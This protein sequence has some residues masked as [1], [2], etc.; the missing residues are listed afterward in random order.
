MG[1]VL[2]FLVISLVLSLPWLGQSATACSLV[3]GVFLQSNFEMIDAADAIVVAQAVRNDA[4][5]EFGFGT[6]YFDVVEVLKG[7]A[8]GEVEGHGVL[9]K[10]PPSDPMEIVRAH[11]E[12]FAGPCNR[13]TFTKG[14]KYVLM[15]SRADDGS[16]L[17]SGDPFSRRSEDDFGP[18]SPW[19]RAIRA[20][21]DIQS[22]PDRIAQMEALESL[23]ETGLKDSATQFEKDLSAD[24]ILHLYNIHPDK[25]FEWLLAR[26]RDPSLLG[27]SGPLYDKIV[28]GTQEEA[29][30][31]MA[32][33]LL[34]ELEEPTS[35]R[36]DILRALV[37]SDYEQAEP[38][39]AEVLKSDDPDP[40]SFGAAISYYIKQGE[41]DLVKREIANSGVWLIA[42]KTQSGLLYSEIQNAI[43]YADDN[44]I[45]AEFVEW[46]ERFSAALCL[47]QN[48]DIECGYDWEKSATL[49]TNVRQYEPLML[50][51]AGAPQIQ[52]WAEAEIDR[53]FKAEISIYDD[54]WEFPVTLLLAGYDPDESVTVQELACGDSAYRYLLANQ[55]GNVPNYRTKKLLQEM[56]A[57]EQKPDIRK[58]LL[59]AGIRLAAHDLTRSRWADADWLVAYA[60]LEGP[61]PLDE[62]DQP[63]LPCLLK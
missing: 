15:L 57:L 14:K 11:P 7:D 32:A 33:F 58:A 43:L 3:R 46:W 53:L 62:D 55:I 39:F 16:L 8:S 17:V 63:H 40:T 26:Y 42:A 54:V 30:D 25:P 41:Y 19:R 61:L 20:Y 6:V 31:Q 2:R 9:G 1:S 29:A 60:K 51:D 12:A 24:T 49:L 5:E 28:A 45:D 47:M 4:E 38:L 18:E 27:D 35:I 48:N 21:L 59:E 36:A 56:M 37:R 50:A 13:L 10:I 23:A 34:D 22:M 52:A 44:E